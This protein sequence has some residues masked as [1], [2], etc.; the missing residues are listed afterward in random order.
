M[1]IVVI[2][3][4]FIAFPFSWFF[5]FFFCSFI[6]FWILLLLLLYYSVHFHWRWTIS[7][8]RRTARNRKELKVRRNKTIF[9]LL[10]SLFLKEKKDFSFFLRIS[11]FDD[12]MKTTAD[13]RPKTNAATFQRVIHRLG[14]YFF[15]S[16]T[17][18]N[19]FFF[20]NENVLSFNP[21]RQ[22]KNKIKSNKSISIPFLFQMVSTSTDTNIIQPGILVFFL[23][24]SPVL[25]NNSSLA[26]TQ[27][28]KV[29]LHF[30]PPPS[31]RRFRRSFAC[32][33]RTILTKTKNKWKWFENDIDLNRFSSKKKYIYIFKNMLSFFC[34]LR[35]R[36]NCL[37]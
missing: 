12:R 11:S 31:R 17:G 34:P 3:F 22:N 13:L 29:T 36:S 35:F 37:C 4:F 26:G 8:H 18:K 15:P 32:R 33:I 10:S 2:A 20:Y 30:P 5:F 23:F 21:P 27:I 14:F 19:P 25:L 1:H 6:F 24:N 9:I 7:I 16:S 28:V